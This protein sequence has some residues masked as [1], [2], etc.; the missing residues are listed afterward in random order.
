MGRSAALAAG[1]CLAG[2]PYAYQAVASYGNNAYL[3]VS[4]LLLVGGHLWL[5]RPARLG[6]LLAFLQLVTLLVHETGALLL[7]LVVLL[8]WAWRR[9]RRAAGDWSRVCDPHLL[10]WLSVDK[11]G[12]DLPGGRRW[13]A[14]LALFGVPIASPWRRAAAF[15]VDSVLGAIVNALGGA[16]VAAAVVAILSL[17]LTLSSPAPRM[18]VSPVATA[19]SNATS[20]TSS[21]NPGISGGTESL[22][23]RKSVV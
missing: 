13:L 14:G 18:R 17:S 10:R 21:T 15:L 5:S 3:T 1:F 16:G 7:P 20:I 8:P 12:A 22:K 4:G 6:A 2:L 11:V 19:P 9:S 23:N